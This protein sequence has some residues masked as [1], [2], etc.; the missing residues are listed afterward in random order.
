[1]LRRL[2]GTVASSGDLAA[3]A[4]FSDP[5]GPLRVWK[6]PPLCH[7]GLYQ[8]FFSGRVDGGVKR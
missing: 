2:R 5:V 3:V 6:I 7:R 4:A 8:Q 1:M